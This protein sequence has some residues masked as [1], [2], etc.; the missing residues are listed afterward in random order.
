MPDSKMF[1]AA[2]LDAVTRAIFSKAGWPD[3]DCAELARHLTGANLAGH[4][5]HGVG[6]IPRYIEAIKRGE[7]T[8]LSRP[9]DV[10]ASGAFLVVDARLALGQKV[11]ADTI[12]R[13]CAIA[14]EGGVCVV[15]LINAHHIG[16]IGHYAEGVA[17]EGFVALFWV[18]VAHAKAPVA[19]F[20]GREGRLG[21]NPHTIGI[22]VADGEPLILDFATSR[23]ALGKV[24]VAHNKGERVGPGTLLDAAG[25]ETTDPGVMYQDPIVA[26][27]TFGEHKG[28]GISI[29]AEILSAVLGLGTSVDQA[30]RNDAINNNLFGVILDP[31]RLGADGET[32]KARLAA[33]AAWLKSSAPRDPARPVLLPGEPERLSRAKRLREGIP[34]DAESWRQIVEAAAWVGV[35]A[36]AVAAS[37]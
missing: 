2:A 37:S 24:R 31:A 17:A 15:N 26:L 8:P 1:S 14:R 7:L 19:P 20:G 30:A 21:T 11:A 13:A 5:S 29:M 4:D 33:Y 23:I 18:N 36:A 34:V 35:D 12:S 3:A 28:S 9:R 16:R 22:P 27:L 6:M 32:R 25:G 10:T